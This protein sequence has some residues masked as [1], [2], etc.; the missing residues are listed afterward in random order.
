MIIG[1]GHVSLRGF[2]RPAKQQTIEDCFCN[3]RNQFSLEQMRMFFTD[4][5]AVGNHEKQNY[6]LRGCLEVLGTETLNN[7]TTRK[8]YR[9]KLKLRESTVYVC[10]KFF[11]GLYGINESRIRRKVR[12]QNNKC[13]IQC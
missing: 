13:K 1:E 8:M 12:H 11:L 5:W 10:R 2:V 7:G 4:F 6:Y 3:C 9:Y